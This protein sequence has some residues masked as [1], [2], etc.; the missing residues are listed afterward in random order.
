MS[1]ILDNEQTYRIETK[2][3]AG[4]IEDPVT[5]EQHEIEPHDDKR[6]GVIEVDRPDS[7]KYIVDS[8][9]RRQF[10]EKAPSAK[11]VQKA[12]SEQF[13]FAGSA[14]CEAF[15]AKQGDFGSQTLDPTEGFDP[16]TDSPNNDKRMKAVKMYETLLS[17]GHD[18]EAGYLR[19]LGGI[20]RQ[21]EF[22]NY[23]RK[24]EELSL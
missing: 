9:S 1:A 7:A 16:A 10:A 23:L 17:E 13:D 15:A 3:S 8:S 5:G 19:S 6:G 18:D 11:A 2:T 12:Q 21:E 20:G 22:V 24:S 4:H 14:V